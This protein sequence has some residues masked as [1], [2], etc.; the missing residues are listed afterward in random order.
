MILAF[1]Q[2]AFSFHLLL[3]QGVLNKYSTETLTTLVFSVSITQN[4][5]WW[6]KV[7]FN[8]QWLHHDK[9][10]QNIH[11]NSW[12]RSHTVSPQLHLSK[13]VLN[14]LKSYIS[15][16]MSE[17]RHLVHQPEVSTAQENDWWW[18]KKLQWMFFYF[19]DTENTV[20]LWSI[21]AQHLWKKLNANSAAPRTSTLDTNT[22][23]VHTS[24]S[25]L[26]NMHISNGQDGGSGGNS[27]LMKYIYIYICIAC[28]LI[29]YILQ[30][31]PLKL[32]IP[33]P[34]ASNETHTK[35]VIQRNKRKCLPVTHSS[36]F[37]SIQ[38]YILVL[39]VLNGLLFWYLNLFK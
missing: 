19:V 29:W 10:Y 1:L 22:L 38:Y 11:R 21:Q 8:T 24:P 31:Q 6:P 27:S 37:H 16:K 32:H 36:R 20:F 33:P 2:S 30:H 35:E 9:P 18:I 23:T 3:C 7:R 5:A 14:M 26:L 13:R 17:K 34:P 15:V 25:M 4:G 28:W 39:S 12:D